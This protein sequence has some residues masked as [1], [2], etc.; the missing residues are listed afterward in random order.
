[1]R[2]DTMDRFI[3]KLTHLVNELGID[4]ELGVADHTIA[5]LLA[6]NCQYFQ[7]ALT[8]IRERNKTDLNDLN[9]VVNLKAL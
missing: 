7:F 8:A 3:S 6:N 2:A 5:V 9:E 1:M 4:N